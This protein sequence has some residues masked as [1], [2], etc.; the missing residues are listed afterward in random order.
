MNP[1]CTGNA[2]T[3]VHMQGRSGEESLD[4][5]WRPE[6]PNSRKSRG[7][8]RCGSWMASL[9]VARCCLA[10]QCRIRS[11]IH[12][13]HSIANRSKTYMLRCLDAILESNLTD[14][15]D[16]MLVVNLWPFW[17]PLMEPVSQWRQLFA[18]P[19]HSNSNKRRSIQ[20][21]R[22]MDGIPTC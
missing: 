15:E 18:C 16:A 12:P 19:S 13:N 6:V 11:P 2:D 21:P 7:S 9:Q 17:P 22:I 10:R 4:C 20:N 1:P 5:C 14:I 3:G 8:H